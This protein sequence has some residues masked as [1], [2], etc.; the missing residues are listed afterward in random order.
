MFFCNQF[1]ITR[2]RKYLK[3]I[4]TVRENWCF[5][6]QEFICI[7]GYTHLYSLHG[8]TRLSK[9][10]NEISRLYS[11]LQVIRCPY[12]IIKTTIRTYKYEINCQLTILSH[13]GESRPRGAYTPAAYRQHVT[14]IRLFR[15]KP[16]TDH[17]Q[18]IFFIYYY[19]FYNVV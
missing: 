18:Y 10:V 1:K 5:S 4:N 11:F 13:S 9:T 3:N 19:Y 12:N 14:S 7:V 16:K 6:L 15:R 2:E 17:A 8:Q